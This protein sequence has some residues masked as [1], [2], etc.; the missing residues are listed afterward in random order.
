MTQSRQFVP[1]WV[2]LPHKK[3]VRRWEGA[4][5]TQKQDRRE[6]LMDETKFKGELDAGKM[7]WIAEVK[8]PG[9]KTNKN[10]CE[11]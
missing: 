5:A 3:C 11:Y 10:H 8:F 6:N 1:K 9:R 2:D 7:V 4:L